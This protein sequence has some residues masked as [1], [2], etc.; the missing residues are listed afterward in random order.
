[1]LKAYGAAAA[2][3]SVNSYGLFAIMTTRRPEIIIEGSND[4]E[5]WFAYEFR[6]KPGNVQRRPL[7]A[8][9]HLPRLDWQMWF[10]ALG[11][12]Q[13][14]AWFRNLLDRLLEGEPEVVALFETNPFPEEPPRFIRAVVYDYHF[15]DWDSRSGTGAWWN[16]DRVGLYGPVLSRSSSP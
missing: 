13:D 10:T 2:F 6:W 14:N 9:P 15:T 3:Q 7:F 4:G 5:H 16:R 1:M 12:P 11:R 8:G